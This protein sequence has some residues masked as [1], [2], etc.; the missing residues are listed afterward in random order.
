VIETSTL[1]SFDTTTSTV[2]VCIF[3]YEYLVVY[4]IYEISWG[5]GAWSCVLSDAFTG[6]KHV[7][8]LSLP[9]PPITSD[10]SCKWPYHCVLVYYYCSSGLFISPSG[11]SDPSGT[12]AGMVTPKGNY[13]G[14]PRRNGRNF[15][16]VFLML[17]YTD[18]TQNTYIQSW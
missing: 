2:I 14:C 4:I 11:I 15:G 17:N 16:R 7:P 1:G 9:P 5:G 6:V 13:T 18:I 8:S 12:V 3:G 10:S